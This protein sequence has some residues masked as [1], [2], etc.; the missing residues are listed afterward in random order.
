MASHR[1]PRTRILASAGPRAAV[2]IT[3]AAL[4][5]VTLMSET[6]HAAPAKP[7]ISEVKKQVDTLNQQAEVATQQYDQAKE[8]TAT[9]R[10]K[11]NQLL[12]QV[13]EK[14]QKMN[15]SR[16]VLGQFAAEQYRNGGLDETTQL[17]LSDDPAGF[18]NQTHLL[19]RLSTTQ[20]QALQTFK[21]QQEQASIQRGQA[22]ASLQELTTSQGKLATQK[23]NVQAKLA[24]AQKLL[25]SL[26]AAE[27]AKLAAMQPKS[28]TSNASY[29]YNGP[30]SGRAAAAIQFA[31]S[32]RGKPYVSGGTGP[33]SYDCSGLTMAA[34]KAAGI[35]IGR[36]TWDQVK[37][38][39]AVSE[40]D[41]R[42]GDLVFFYSGISH[43]GIY[44][45]N[46]NVVHAPHTGATVEIA[47]M[48]WM[49]FAA[50]R[51]IA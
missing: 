48:S 23:K 15:E 44:L 51:R 3:S 39:T 25:N 12:A 28:S 46:G 4:A 38:G 34:Y 29:T 40:S 19:D 42:P 21:V 9:Q 17:L 2:G 18:L 41:L 1:K 8:K 37:D 47:P 26:N 24:S 16:R 27:R 22:T 36:T 11:T 6:A 43:V 13:A 35:T 33:N 5:S 31:L 30:A 49:P 20:E 7:S 14:T 45:G 32:Q 10:T 50:A